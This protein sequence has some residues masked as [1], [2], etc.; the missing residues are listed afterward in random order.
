[1]GEAGQGP[2]ASCQ[3]ARDAPRI[4]QPWQLRRERL[5]SKETWGHLPD[6]RR[7]LIWNVCSLDGDQTEVELLGSEIFRKAA[8][9]LYTTTASS[10]K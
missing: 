10:Q 6:G 9:T 4:W 2:S 1:M 5:G 8:L 7:S 3:P